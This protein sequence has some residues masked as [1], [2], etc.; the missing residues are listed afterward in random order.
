MLDYP[1]GVSGCIGVHCYPR[2]TPICYPA[3]NEAAPGLL[4]TDPGA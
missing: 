1:L 3:S 4:G 2:A